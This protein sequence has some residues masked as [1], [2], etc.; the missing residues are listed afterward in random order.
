MQPDPDDSAPKLGVLVL[1]ASQF[2]NYPPSRRLDNESFARSSAA[3]RDIMAAPDTSLLGEAAILDLFDSPDEPAAIIRRIRKFLEQHGGLT[4]IVIYYCGHGDF[5]ADSS[6]TYVLMLRATEPDN[7]AFTAL[8]P[9]QMRVALDAQLAM[10]R[11]FLVFDCCFA[12]KAATEWQADGIGHVVE[13][14]LFQ[15]FPKRGTALLAASSKGEPALAPAAQGLTMFTG[16][17]VDVIAGGIEGQQRQISFRDVFQ[18]TRT[19][20][21]EGHGPGAAVPVI[22]APHQPEGDISFDPFFLNR[23][24]ALPPEPEARPAE[25]ENFELAIA[26]L[27][28][29]ASL[30]RTRIAAVE[31]LAELLQ[32]T[33]SRT[34]R[35]EI[36]SELETARETDDSNTV[37]AACREILKTFVPGDT[38]P[39]PGVSRNTTVSEEQ[40]RKAPEKKES[41][42]NIKVIASVLDS[43]GL[44]T[45]TEAITDIRSGKTPPWVEKSKPIALEWYRKATTA[46]SPS[47]MYALGRRYETGDGIPAD[48]EEAVRWYERAAAYESE[49]AREALR[50]LGRMP[51]P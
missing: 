47:E 16:A 34:L 31:T 8:P 10:K 35:M 24:Y 25:R 27:H 41:A 6:K 19:R 48:I 18:Q 51:R 30:P 15:A 37:R 1:G 29:T 50:R 36:V 43:L 32:E 20:I 39:D 44:R 26:D 5:L 4:D 3:F 13:E 7:E 33:K 12:G 23:G 2:P 38:P 9:R 14:Q 22:H 11:V 46:G 21:L 45:V 17:L 28:R 49:D 42:I 40:R